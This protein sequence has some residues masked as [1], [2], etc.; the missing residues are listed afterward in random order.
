VLDKRVQAHGQHVAGDAEPLLELIEAGDPQEGVAQ[1]QQ[2]PPLADHLERA[3]DRA[4]HLFEGHAL[5]TAI[6]SL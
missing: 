2:C 3:G 4:V 6:V 1:D 5:H